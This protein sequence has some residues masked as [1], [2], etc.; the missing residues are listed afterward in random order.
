M[1]LRVICSSDLQGVIDGPGGPKTT[2]VGTRQGPIGHGF[3]PFRDVGPLVVRVSIGGDD[4]HKDL[5]LTI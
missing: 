3:P 1:G 5:E 2:T 4:G